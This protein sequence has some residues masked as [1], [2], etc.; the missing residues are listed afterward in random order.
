MDLLQELIR[1]SVNH[2][3]QK[4]GILLFSLNSIS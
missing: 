1:H 3:C 4:K 2:A